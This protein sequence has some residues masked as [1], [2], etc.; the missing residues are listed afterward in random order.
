MTIVITLVSAIISGILAT[1][2]TLC[3]NH[4]ME[5]KRIKRELLYDVFGYR[6]LLTDNSKTDGQD[7]SLLNRALNRIP[8][9]FNK[10]QKVM[11]AYDKFV[12]ANDTVDKNDIFITLCK[13]MCIDVGIN[14]DNWNDSKIT[15]TIIV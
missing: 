2:I 3:V 15:K 11:T 6:Y 13:E 10:N 7:T 14:V 4:H 1:I 5:T 9:I 8:I 12:L